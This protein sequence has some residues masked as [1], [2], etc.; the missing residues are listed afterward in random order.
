MCLTN[1]GLPR[2]PATPVAKAGEPQPPT[3]RSIHVK[4]FRNIPMADLDV[5]LVSPPMVLCK[6]SWAWCEVGRIFVN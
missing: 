6:Q 2:R 4:H 1:I 3:D 5:V